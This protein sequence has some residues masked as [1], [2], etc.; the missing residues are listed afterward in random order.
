IDVDHV[1]PRIFEQ[2]LE[3]RISR[4]NSECIADGIQLFSRPLAN[5]VHVGTWMPL[6]NGNEFRSESE[7]NN[8]YVDF[9]H[10]LRSR[11]AI[12]RPNSLRLWRGIHRSSSFVSIKKADFQIPHERSDTGIDNRA[13]I[14]VLHSKFFCWSILVCDPLVHFFRQTA[15]S[16]FPDGWPA[17]ETSYF[18]SRVR[19]LPHC[20]SLRVVLFRGQR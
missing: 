9:L 7:A 17:I 19:R 13:A 12:V 8:G 6:I 11:R 15:A 10:A 2:L 16:L 18:G 1:H 20:K 3:I 14:S 4:L 5:C